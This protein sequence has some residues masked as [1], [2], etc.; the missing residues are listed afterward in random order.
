MD[1][2]ANLLVEGIFVDDLDV[3]N[4]TFYMVGKTR[5]APYIF[6]SRTHSNQRVDAVDPAAR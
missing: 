5:S 2:V 3:V 6:F 1:Q 4:K